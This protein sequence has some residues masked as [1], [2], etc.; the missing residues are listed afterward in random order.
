MLYFWVD[1]FIYIITQR[2]K[3]KKKT[4]IRFNSFVKRFL[5]RVHWNCRWDTFS[6][7]KTTFLSLNKKKTKK[8]TKN[9][10]LDEHFQSAFSIL[11]YL[12]LLHSLYT[13]GLHWSFFFFSHTQYMNQIAPRNFVCFLIHIHTHTHAYANHSIS[14]FVPMLMSLKANKKANTMKHI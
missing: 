1:F 7:H 2:K 14:I 6:V 13:L 11:S 5:F 3:F 8:R 4:E 9:S 10:D 12:L